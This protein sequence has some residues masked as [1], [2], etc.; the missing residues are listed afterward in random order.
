MPVFGFGAFG[1][2]GGGRGRVDDVAAGLAG[3]LHIVLQ[4]AWVG[5]EILPGSELGRVD[6]DAGPPRPAELASLSDQGQVALGTTGSS[7][8]DVS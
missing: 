8:L 6:E 4:S 3:T 1:V 2:H 7:P 5:L